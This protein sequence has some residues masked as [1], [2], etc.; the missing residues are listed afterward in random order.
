MLTPIAADWSSGYAV[1]AEASYIF[2]YYRY[3][4]QLEGRLVLDRC[5]D[6]IE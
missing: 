5:N 6:S 1:E 3:L 2:E 4:R